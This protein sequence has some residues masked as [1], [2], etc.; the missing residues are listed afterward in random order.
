MHGLIRS[1]VLIKD[2]AQVARQ[3]A[4]K[5]AVRAG[6]RSKDW[7]LPGRALYGRL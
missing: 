6:E 4:L 3:V 2:M 1:L 7:V 5:V